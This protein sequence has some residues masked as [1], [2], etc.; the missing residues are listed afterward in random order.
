M[1]NNNPEQQKQKREKQ[2]KRE[3]QNKKKGLCAKSL[4]KNAKGNQKA[5][6][7]WKNIKS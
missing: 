7:I 2:S 6:A 1:Q 5:I 3:K 4:S